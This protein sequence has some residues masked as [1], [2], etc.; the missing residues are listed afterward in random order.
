MGIQR[1]QTRNDQDLQQLRRRP[2]CSP[3]QLP[4][5]PSH[6]LPHRPSH[7]LPHRLPHFLPHPRCL[8]EDLLHP[9]RRRYQRVHLHQ[10]HPHPHFPQGRQGCCQPLLSAS[11]LFRPHHRRGVTHA[12]TSP[13]RFSAFLLLS[14]M[15]YNGHAPF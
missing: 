8:Q 7:R 9:L 10:V 4:H 11:L 3:H 12:P 13:A 6:Q 1:V 14:N 5:R 2:N 15:L